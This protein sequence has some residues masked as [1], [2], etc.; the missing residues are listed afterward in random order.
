MFLLAIHANDIPR[1]KVHSDFI[2]MGTNLLF[3][4]IERL[5]KNF[6]KLSSE[7]L[8][9]FPEKYSKEPFTTLAEELQKVKTSQKP[10]RSIINCRK[11]IRYFTNSIFF[12]L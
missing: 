11:F 4:R 9:K 8:K 6:T 2:T 1:P 12:S 5:K 7:A 3:E 10:T